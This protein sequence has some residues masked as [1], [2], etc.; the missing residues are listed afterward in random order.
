MCGMFSLGATRGSSTAMSNEP[1]AILEKQ[2]IERGK[3]GE[4]GWGARQAEE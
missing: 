3:A 4:R 2:D 1:D